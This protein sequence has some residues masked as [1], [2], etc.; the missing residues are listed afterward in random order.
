MTS[1]KAAVRFFA[2]I[3]AGMLVLFT[4]SGCSSA[5]TTDGQSDDTQQAETNGGSGGTQ[6]LS[7]KNSSLTYDS[8]PKDALI[9]ADDLN[10][11]YTDASV[12]VVDVRGLGPYSRGRIPGSRNIPAGRQVEIRFN[13]FDFSKEVVLVAQNT[14]R[15]AEVRQTLIDL[16]GDESKI[17]VLDGGLDA[18]IAAGYETFANPETGC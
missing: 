6:S 18:W 1:G 15:V 12:E 11:I 4:V 7:Q 5:A 3:M 14:E 8:I 17:R 2:M 10:R 13:E 9:S 16:G